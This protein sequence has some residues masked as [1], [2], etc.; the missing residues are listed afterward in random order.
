[1]VSFEVIKNNPSLY[2]NLTHNKK[3]LSNL[4]LKSS[5]DLPYSCHTIVSN[6]I[7]KERKKKTV[8]N[9]KKNKKIFAHGLVI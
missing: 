4:A 8:T 1:M 7:R 9:G 2:R 5:F 6:R 3:Y